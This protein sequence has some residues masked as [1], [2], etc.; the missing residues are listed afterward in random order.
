MVRGIGAV[1]HAV[2]GILGIHRRFREGPQE[3][4]RG[5]DRQGQVH[6]TV[7]PRHHIRGAGADSAADLLS[8]STRRSQGF[9]ADVYLV[10]SVVSDI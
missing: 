2:D 9:L 6:R 4:E 5:T 8:G 3:A 7:H 10:L 1:R